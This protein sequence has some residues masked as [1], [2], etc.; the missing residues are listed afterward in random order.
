MKG[1]VLNDLV[2]IMILV[3]FC[4][5][6]YTHSIPEY[7]SY[8]SHTIIPKLWTWFGTIILTQYIY[9]IQTGDFISHILHGHIING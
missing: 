2:V 1:N 3:S 8:D 4:F 6:D 7:S 9:D 5:E